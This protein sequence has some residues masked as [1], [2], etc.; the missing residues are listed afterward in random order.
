M[1]VKNPTAKIPVREKKP[2]ALIHLKDNNIIALIIYNLQLALVIVTA[3]AAR[4][5]YAV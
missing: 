5:H 4:N 1:G 2:I 3:L